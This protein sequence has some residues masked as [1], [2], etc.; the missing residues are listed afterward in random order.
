MAEA[1]GMPNLTLKTIVIR[2]AVII[3]LIE[4][5]IMLG[6]AYLPHKFDILTEAII[7]V[8]L[9]VSIASP[10]F[11][12]WIIKPFIIARDEILTQL[13]NMAY[14][15]QLT[16]LPNRRVLVRDIEKLISESVRHH[17]YGA[18][19]L[20]DLDD[21]KPINDTYGHFAGDVVLTEIANRLK[22]NIRTEDVASRI[23]GD[24]FVILLNR[25]KND[26]AL[27]RKE[28]T[29]LAEKLL[30]LVCEPV[31]YQGA[32]LNVG[33]SIGIRLLG[34]NMIGVDA[35][36]RQADSAMYKAKQKGKGCI[37]IFSQDSE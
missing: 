10:F 36:I 4:L 28:A 19:L 15:D 25:L 5:M 3:A 23:G 2:M 12:I 26:A 20:L 11:Y 14:S 30:K 27:A 8:V 13:S 7:D 31:N 35:A 18:L 17:Y 6:F 29:D 22:N 21:F 24:E 33:V 37:V 34:D 32:E 16:G 9:L 1:S